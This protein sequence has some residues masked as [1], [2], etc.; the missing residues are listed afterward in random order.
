[1]KT[2]FCWYKYPYTYFFSPLYLEKVLNQKKF[3]KMYYDDSYY[4]LNHELD[5]LP[6]FK[7]GNFLHVLVESRVRN[8]S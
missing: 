4:Q 1:M 6:E 7:G 2:S 3:L 5:Q 8:E